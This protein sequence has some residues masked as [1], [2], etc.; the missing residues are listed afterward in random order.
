VTVAQSG[1]WDLEG[2]TY[3]WD[4]LTVSNGATAW[5]E[6]GTVTITDLLVIEGATLKLTDG[7]FVL[8]NDVSLTDGNMHL[9]DTT[10]SFA[11]LVLTDNCSVVVYDSC[12]VA[13]TQS[14]TVADSSSLTLPP[15]TYTFSSLTFGVDSTLYLPSQ[16]YNLDALHVPVGSTLYPSYPIGD[17]AAIN[18]DSGGTAGNPHG[19]GPTFNISGNALI[20]GTVSVEGM[21]F[22]TRSGPGGSG[23]TAGHGGEGT[24]GGIPPTYGRLTR[25]T[26]LGSGSYNAAG[27]G[28]VTLHV[29]GTLTVDG[30]INAR[31]QPVN[32][33]SAG[34][35]VWMTANAFAGGGLIQ[36]D[37][38]GGTAYAGGG[39]RVAIE[40]TASTF[41]GTVSVAGGEE[42]SVPGYGP[43]ETGTVYTCRAPCPGFG[44]TGCGGVTLETDVALD[45]NGTRISRVITHW[46]PSSPHFRWTDT[47]T[48][49][50]GNQ[51]DTLATY[52]LEGLV[53]N[54]RLNVYD[55]DALLF[56][57]NSGPI[58]SI[59]FAIVL[60]SPHTLTIP[61]PSGTVVLLR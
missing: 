6:N 11:S 46:D 42:G 44:L 5:F 37:S 12:T 60:D 48:D 61:P 24:Y 52:T 16:T 56:T 22:P 20:E 13:I 54:Q 27:G 31:S 36:A 30:T 10:F 28:A 49:P 23:G 1:H 40:Y 58:G 21:G 53:P 41:T 7:T 59:T 4:L 18:A 45:K 29:S 26:A 3:N 2:G 34:G 51:R 19:E 57:T 39:G 55:N 47:S 50:N 33:G 43:G 8:A 15:G 32:H 9:E 25:P 35:S 38:Y 17:T 14:L